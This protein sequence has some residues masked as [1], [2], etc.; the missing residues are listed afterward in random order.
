MSYDTSDESKAE[1]RSE[2]LVPRTEY[3]ACP[4]CGGHVAGAMMTSGSIVVDGVTYYRPS[5]L[6]VYCT[7]CNYDKPL[8]DLK[9]P[10]MVAPPPPPAAAEV[11][12]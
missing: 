11:A 5:A 7:T 3:P 12:R 2:Q 6:S 8:S 9:T 4:R 10:T 1:T